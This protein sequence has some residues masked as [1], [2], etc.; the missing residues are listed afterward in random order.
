V[1]NNCNGTVDDGLG[2]RVC[3]LGPC[4]RTVAACVGGVS[5]TCTPGTPGTETCNGIDDDCD[6]VI[7]NGNCAPTSVCPGARQVTPNTSVTLN[8]NASSPVGRAVSCSWS[9]VSRPATSSGT[10]SAPTSCTATNYMAD[11]VG[12]HTLRFTVTDSMGLT[13]TCTTTVE[14]LPTGDLWIELTWNVNNDMD[15]HLLHPS[16]GRPNRAASWND[17]VFDCNY[18]NKT[19][20]WDVAGTADDPS[21]DQDVVSGMGPENTRINVASTTHVYN[22]GVHMYSWS[23]SP[24]PVVATV[25]VYCAGQLKTTQTKSFNTLKQMWVVGAVDF[26]NAG[27]A[28][29]FFTPDGQTVS[30]P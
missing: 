10:F 27:A 18:I 13:S 9:V 6:G 7:D 24:T 30:V 29:C 4:Q 28:G 15:L 16:A 2:N 20:S 11:V 25:R 19:P 1:D 17:P 22:I 14:V 3:G 21:L 5:Q 26:K 23:A 12:I 8:T